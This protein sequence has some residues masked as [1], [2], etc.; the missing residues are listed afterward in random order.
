MSWYSPSP[1]GYKSLDTSP[2]EEGSAG[3]NPQ[4]Q[5]PEHK[6]IWNGNIWDLLVMYLGRRLLPMLPRQRYRDATPPIKRVGLLLAGLRFSLKPPVY[7]SEGKRVDPPACHAG[8]SGFEPRRSRQ[9]SVR[10]GL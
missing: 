7:G 4:H 8:D 10:D 6:G 5:T 1:K 9:Q 2:I 3:R